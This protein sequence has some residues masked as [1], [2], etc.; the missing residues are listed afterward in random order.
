MRWF[1]KDNDN[2][3]RVSREEE[4]RL[5]QAMAKQEECD[6]N[7]RE[8]ANHRQEVQSQMNELGLVE[9]IV[10][11]QHGNSA[12]AYVVNAGKTAEAILGLGIETHLKQQTD[13][14]I[15]CQGI[16]GKPELW[17][18]VERDLGLILS[19]ANG[20]KLT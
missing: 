20:G 16:T 3:H 7:A 2:Y 5:Q 18:C 19:D 1:R 8:L 4:L 15:A 6:R 11:D 17:D 12:K 13:F 10:R 9:T 14:D